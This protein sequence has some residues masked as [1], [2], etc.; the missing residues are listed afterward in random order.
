L[1]ASSFEGEAGECTQLEASY[2]PI[3]VDVNSNL[4]DDDSTTTTPASSPRQEEI[5]NDMTEEERKK[6]NKKRRK[7]RSQLRRKQLKESANMSLESEV[8][9]QD[10]P[11]EVLTTTESADSPAALPHIVTTATQAT[12]SNNRNKPGHRKTRSVSNVEIRVEEV[13]SPEG[14]IDQW[15]Q[16]N[17][18]ISRSL[19]PEFHFFSDTELDVVSADGSRPPTPIHSD[20]EYEVRIILTFCQ[21]ILKSTRFYKFNVI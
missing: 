2:K 15:I 18:I 4:G 6:W 10:V 5:P 12:T 9:N 1:N 21:R 20:T 3:D 14:R 13:S 19:G 16:G 11:G 17:A 8:G 7:R